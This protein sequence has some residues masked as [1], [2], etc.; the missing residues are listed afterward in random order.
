MHESLVAGVVGGRAGRAGR[1]GG[2]G[3][4]GEAFCNLMNLDF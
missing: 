2:P 1:G 3:L 4:V